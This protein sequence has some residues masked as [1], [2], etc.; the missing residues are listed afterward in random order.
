MCLWK[1]RIALY[2]LNIRTKLPSHN[3]KDMPVA[4]FSEL[5]TCESYYVLR[6]TEIVKKSINFYCLPE[7]IESENTNLFW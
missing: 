2:F 6:L 1:F 5:I 3:I 4:I 7:F